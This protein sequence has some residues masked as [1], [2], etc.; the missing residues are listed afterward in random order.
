MKDKVTITCVVCKKQ[1][2]TSCYW[3]V[4][5]SVECRKKRIGTYQ[6]TSIPSNTVGAI[7]ELI[8]SS[9]LMKK[10]F[11]VFKSL[12]PSCFCD[13]IAVKGDVT[14]KI[15]IRT[16]YKRAN[17]T[18][19]YPTKTHGKIDIF[20]IYDRNLDKCFYFDLNHKEVVFK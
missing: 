1:I 6:D 7:S 12:S 16:G 3:Q 2:K 17:G 5:C 14:L 20:G 19:F 10:G 8:V 4:T 9:D 18:I 13:V 15:E 11:S